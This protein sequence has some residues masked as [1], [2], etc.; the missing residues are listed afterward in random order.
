ML[1]RLNR[2]TQFI[3]TLIKYKFVLGEI[4]SKCIL[5]PAR[6]VGAK[7]IYI[8]SRVTIFYGTRIEAITSY[9][10][11]KYNPKLIINS[12]VK[13]GQNCHITCAESIEIGENCEITS[14]VT[15]TDQDHMHVPNVDRPARLPTQTKKVLIEKNCVLFNNC[16]ILPGTF[17]GANSFVGANSVVRG[18]FPPNSIIKGISIESFKQSGQEKC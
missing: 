13:I 15:I 3:V 6:L 5:N 11:S 12:N 4:G 17:I 18:T 9:G 14:N 2:L 8:G 1:K 7:N 16:V 10:G